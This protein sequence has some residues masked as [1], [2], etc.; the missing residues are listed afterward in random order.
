MTRNTVLLFLVAISAAAHFSKIQ[1]RFDLLQT[2]T[3]PPDSKPVIIPDR[4]AEFLD[5]I[6]KSK[7]H[8]EAL[9]TFNPAAVVR[10]DSVHVLYRAEDD[11]GAMQIGMHT[12]RLGLA[13]SSDGIHFTRKPEPVFYAAKDGQQDREWPGGVEDPR[14]VESEDGTY[15]LTYTQWNRKTYTVGVATSRDLM[16]WQKFGPAFGAVGKYAGLQYK[17]AGILTELRGNRL[18]AA[19]VNGKYWMYW[20]E[21]HVG[22]ATS[23]DLIHW[24]PVED[25]NGSPIVLM[26]PR[27]GMF[28]SALPEVGPPPVL[29]SGRIVLLYNGKNAATGGDPKLAPGA[30]SVGIAI[31]DGQNPAR[32]VG[33]T[34]APIFRPEEAW[35]RSGQYRAG[36]TFAEGLVWFRN[37]WLL[38][39][40][41][42]DSLVGVAVSA[43]LPPLALEHSVH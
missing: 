32:L 20:G 3:R 2:F 22:L 42:A 21:I 33:R 14:L 7:V 37:K 29:T 18:L 4:G 38:Y 23:P 11:S 19:R 28:D 40:G 34:D 12:S 8:W 26:A 43:E 27:P 39:Y 41:A 16:H 15:V 17:S 9:H 31:F 35:E 36:T 10:G 1:T 24:T 25:P 5:P 6:L 30:Y 13:E